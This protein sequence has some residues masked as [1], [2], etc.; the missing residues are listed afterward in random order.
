MS[1]P[2]ANHS[3]E[4]IR[5]DTVADYRVACALNL[6]QAVTVDMGEGPL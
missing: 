5:K 3:R 6:T 1:H 4:A 2:F